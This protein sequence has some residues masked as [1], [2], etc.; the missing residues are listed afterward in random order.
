MQHGKHTLNPPS[1]VKSPR[2][3]TGVPAGCTDAPK[4]TAAVLSTATVAPVRVCSVKPFGSLA[5][6][7]PLSWCGV[8]AGTGLTPGEYVRR[9][10]AGP[11]GADVHIGLGAADL[12]RVADFHWGDG[13]PDGAL[14]ADGAMPADGALARAGMA[15]PDGAPHTG[16]TPSRADALMALN[17]YFNPPDLSG[18]GVVN[19]AA[20]RTAEIPSANAHASAGGVARLYSALAAGGAIDGVKVVDRGALAAAAEEQVYGDDLVLRGPFQVRPRLSAVAR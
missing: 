19:S 2:T 20:W 3:N 14:P 12:R 11:L 6:Y 7:S 8:A 4:C 13:P 5:T 9:E 16:Q 18:R 17:A 15:P 1:A 10:V